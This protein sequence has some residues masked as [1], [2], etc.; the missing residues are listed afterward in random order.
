MLKSL[1]YHLNTEWM[2][3]YIFYKQITF[4]FENLGDILVIIL[5]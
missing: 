3:F 4:Y 5:K 1:K 2:L